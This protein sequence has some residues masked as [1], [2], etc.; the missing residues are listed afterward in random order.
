MEYISNSLD[1][2]EE[3]ARRLA[4][5]LSPGRVLLLQGDLGAGK[6]AFTRGFLSHW[7]LED[8]VSSPTFTIMN[9]YKNDD[10]LIYHFDLY[11]MGDETE[12]YE[13]GLDDYLES[14]DY[15]LIEWPGL[16]REW[17]PPDCIT[18]ELNLGSSETER[19]INITGV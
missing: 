13:L 12:L 9:E 11:R 4:S 17:L 7:S 2:T 6:T 15:V 14:G 16:A 3:I 8:W 1:R 18:V 5:E 19:I 10:I